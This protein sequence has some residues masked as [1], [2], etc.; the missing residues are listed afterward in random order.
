M[1]VRPTSIDS[2]TGTSRITS[3]LTSRAASS[4][5]CGAR[6]ASDFGIHLWF[7]LGFRAAASRPWRLLRAGGCAA[8]N[9][10]IA[11]RVT[12]RRR[13]GTAAR[14]RRAPWPCRRNRRAGRRRACRSTSSLQRDA[15]AAQDGAQLDLGVL[16]TFLERGQPALVL[17][18]AVGLHA[19]VEHF[20]QRFDHRVRQHDVQHAAAAVEFDLERAHHH[21]F[22]RRDD[23][24]EVRD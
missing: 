19:G 17:L 23:A 2:V 21:D 16:Q 6:A 14:P 1:R 15:A 24:G 12:R 22:G 9:G 11:G 3:R 13:R 18:G 8:R 7:P 5:S 10:H 20:A 4:A